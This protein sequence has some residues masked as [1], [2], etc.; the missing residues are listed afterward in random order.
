MS[1]DAIAETNRSEFTRYPFDVVI[2][3]LPDK[4]DVSDPISIEP[5]SAKN[6]IRDPDAK[7]ICAERSFAMVDPL[8][9]SVLIFPAEND[10]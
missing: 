5:T 6:T 4:T 8:L 7:S 10:I 2:K 1:N 9:G 3:T